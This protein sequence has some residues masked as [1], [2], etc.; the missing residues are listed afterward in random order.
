M[1]KAFKTY[2]SS[3]IDHVSGGGSGICRALGG[4]GA[5]AR[6]SRIAPRSW[7]PQDSVATLI[8]ISVVQTIHN[9]ISETFINVPRLSLNWW[10][11]GL[12]AGNCL[13]ASAHMHVEVQPI[14]RALA[15]RRGTAMRPN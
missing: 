4:Q 2:G 1:F 14:L 12:W 7:P 5:A 6:E 15:D 10:H 8:A 9:I 3:A 11:F 13:Y